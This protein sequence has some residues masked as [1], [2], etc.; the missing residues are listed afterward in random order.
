VAGDA[1]KP[2]NLT[3]GAG[4]CPAGKCIVDGRREVAVSRVLRAAMIAASWRGGSPQGSPL[5]AALE[6]LAKALDQ[7]ADVAPS[8]SR[9]PPENNDWHASPVGPGRQVAP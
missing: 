2:G 5:R 7:W 6:E 8:G 4:T 9:N 1:M 3:R